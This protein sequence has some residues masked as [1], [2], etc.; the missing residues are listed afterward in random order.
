MRTKRVLYNYLHFGR[1]RV[2]KPLAARRFYHKEMSFL[3]I[4]INN[5][6]RHYHEWDPFHEW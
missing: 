1:S 2:G 4:F 5:H 6:S 3:G